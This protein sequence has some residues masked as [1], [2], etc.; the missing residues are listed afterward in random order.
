MTCRHWGFWSCFLAGLA[1]AS[2]GWGCGTKKDEQAEDGTKKEPFNPAEFTVVGKVVIRTL[3]ATDVSITLRCGEDE[4]ETTTDNDGKYSLTADVTGCDYFTVEFD[5]ESYL[6]NMRVVHLP[7]LTSP[8]QVDVPLVEL[9]EMQCGSTLCRTQNGRVEFTP[10]P[11]A[12]G[13]VA[14]G[15]GT[16]SLDLVPGEFRDTKGELL[17]LSGYAYF[18]LKDDSGERLVDM[19]EKSVCAVVDA[20][21]LDWLGDADP[22]TDD[23]E[24]LFYRLELVTGRWRPNAQP[25]I[26]KY[27]LGNRY[28]KVDEKCEYLKDEDGQTM[29]NW[30]GLKNSE[31]GDIRAQNF[32]V[33]NPCSTADPKSKT[34]ITKVGICLPVEGSGF[35]AWGLAVKHSTCFFASM[36][37]QCGEPLEGIAFSVE[38]RDHGYRAKRWT[39]ETGTACIEAHASEPVGEDFDLDLLGGETFWVNAVLDPLSGSTV[40]IDDMENPRFTGEAMSCEHPESCVQIERSVNVLG[41]CREP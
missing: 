40:R 39:D 3:P 14:V 28:E 27:V 29:P 11:V 37:N 30:V 19:P 16:N 32:Y 34:K 8:I 12:H 13:W 6:P 18:D 21:V 17:S 23:V 36:A 24:M 41:A 1:A 5:K 33:E 31:L 20:S 38:G 25:G 26:V 7:L 22:T 9:T 15:S 2:L 35:Y 4:A 10:D